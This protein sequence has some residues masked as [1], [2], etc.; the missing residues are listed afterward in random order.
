MSKTQGKDTGSTQEK[1]KKI[2]KI[3][4][5]IIRR[6]KVN[7]RTEQRS[8]IQSLDGSKT[9]I[10][11]LLKSVEFGL[12]IFTARFLLSKY[13]NKGIGLAFK[14]QYFFVGFKF[15]HISIFLVF[16]IHNTDSSWRLSQDRRLVSQQLQGSLKISRNHSRSRWFRL[17]G[18]QLRI[19][20]SRSTFFKGFIAGCL[21]G[22]SVHLQVQIFRFINQ[23]VLGYCFAWRSSDFR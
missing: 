15:T 23:L 20:S 5:F 16:N 8:S 22:R 17:L 21:L 4:K 10:R 3:I 13:N 6:Y 19:F 1:K 14:T 7:T 2:R 18:Y 11:L 9:V 12:F